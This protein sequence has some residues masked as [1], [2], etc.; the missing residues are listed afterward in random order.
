MTMMNFLIETKTLEREFNLHV[1][2][3]FIRFVHILRLW[4]RDRDEY[5][6]LICHPF[7]TL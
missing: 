5:K 4:Q 7:K 1:I 3:E 6:L 2:P